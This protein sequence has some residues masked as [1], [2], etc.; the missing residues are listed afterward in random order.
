MSTHAN[1]VMKRSLKQ[2]IIEHAL[3]DAKN[4]GFEVLGWLTGFAVDTTVYICDTV[5]CNK[6]RKQSRYAA[7]AEPTEESKLASRYP[8]NVG[9]VGLYHSHPFKPEYSMGE[10]RTIHGLDV[11]FHSGTDDAML[12]SRA[13]RMKNYVSIVT[14]VDNITCYVMV[15]GRAKKVKEELV[16]SIH[17]KEHMQPL[18]AK[19]HLSME[20]N[21]KI[22][23]ALN[24][25]VRALE[26]YLIEHVSSSIRKS[27]VEI[28]EDLRNSYMRLLPFEKEDGVNPNDLKG[29]YLRINPGKDGISVKATMNISPTIYVP[30]KEIDEAQAIESMKNEIGDYIIYL[31]WNQIDYAEF[32]KH[33]D[34]GVKELGIH[35]GK[36]GTKYDDISQLPSRVYT[37]PKRRMMLKR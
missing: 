28:H 29:N 24:N 18:T 31:L 2:N 3:D 13:S 6:Y 12:R 1:I 10:F 33:I 27:N 37:K 16:K 36:L 15:K 17:F 14:D 22:P 25:I 9:I 19:V 32:E 4:L 35:L 7:E 34:S 20:R 11:M 30:R 26:S 5:R 21:F 23:I 8:R